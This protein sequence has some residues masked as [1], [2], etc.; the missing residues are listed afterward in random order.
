MVM[1]FEAQGHPLQHPPAAVA[2][3]GTVLNQVCLIE[4]CTNVRGN[5]RH[6]GSRA[7]SAT[8]S[9]AVAAPSTNLN[10][11]C[12]IDKCTNVSGANMHLSLKGFQFDIHLPLMLFRTQVLDLACLNETYTGVTGV[13]SRLELKLCFAEGSPLQLNKMMPC[14]KVWRTCK[15]LSWGSLCH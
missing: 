8:F 13:V 7:S 12:L 10:G 9:A 4:R 3:P 1:H 2:A 5:C 11:V 15:T 14:F 6:L